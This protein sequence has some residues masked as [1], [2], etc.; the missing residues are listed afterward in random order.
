MKIPY[1]PIL[2]SL[3]TTSCTSLHRSS[4]SG[5]AESSGPNYKRV[6]KVGERFSNEQPDAVSENRIRNLERK[7]DSKKEREQY[8][9]VLPWLRTET[10]KIEFLSISG[11][12]NRQD[13]LNQKKI[14]Q[15][16]Q[17]PSQEY[18]ELIDSQDIAIGMPMDFV[19]K[20]WGEPQSVESSGSP[21]FKNERWKYTRHI[22]TNDGFKQE[23]RY[24]YFEGGRVVGWET[25]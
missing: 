1:F 5:Y 6:Y 8:A 9:K 20:S 16:A 7:L 10:E 15:R 24:V 17:I 12:E 11:I 22:S 21:T 3:I 25:E 4:T 13:W 19:K 18:K 14:W 2:F 23:R